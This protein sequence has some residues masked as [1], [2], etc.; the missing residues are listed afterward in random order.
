VELTRAQMSELR[1]IDTLYYSR[2][3]GAAAALK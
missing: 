1:A 3:A 2:L